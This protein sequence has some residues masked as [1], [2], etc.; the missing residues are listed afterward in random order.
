M[1]D[2]TDIKDYHVIKW[3][4]C[5]SIAVEYFSI[6]LQDPSLKCFFNS[7]FAAGIGER[8]REL[9][10]AEFRILFLLLPFILL[11]GAFESDFIER[12]TVFGISLSKDNA[13][14]VVLLLISAILILFSSTVS[15]VSGYYSEILSAYINAHCD[16][17][18]A[19]FYRHQFQWDIGS[20]FSGL[21]D[22]E[23]HVHHNLLTVAIVCVWGLALIF[24]AIIVKVLMLLI[25]AGAIVSTWNVSSMSEFVT[26]PIV[27]V[28]MCALVFDITSMLLRCPL[29][30]TDYSNISKI[31]DLEITDPV[32]AAQIRDNIAR[33]GLQ[34]DRR[35]ILML[36]F[37]V[38]IWLIISA[39]FVDIGTELFT[40]YE[41]I[42]QILAALVLVELLTPSVVN[43]IERR[44]LARVFKIA[45]KELSFRRYVSI[46]KWMW[47]AR[48]VLAA[49]IG[50]V[51]FFWFR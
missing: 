26:I 5:I 19:K 33:R 11:L 7:V 48:V 24:A 18:T 36:Q 10:R 6:L 13:T 43:T 42:L 20:I 40:K 51:V 41:I 46:K 8:L 25:F 27:L 39:T 50:V 38:V 44:L 30:F 32:Q 3:R 49:I 31:N 1:T 16:E 12:I 14:I 29:P 17:R 45:D 9:H 35:N 2:H 28:A 21:G 15:T 37:S 47:R 34:R 23:F 22:K 4:S